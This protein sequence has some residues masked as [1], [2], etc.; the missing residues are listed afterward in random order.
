MPNKEIGS[1]KPVITVLRHEPKN[2]KTIKI[3]LVGQPNVGKSMLI[4]SISN[5]RLK[6]GNFSGVTVTKEQVFLNLISKEGLTT[7]I[8]EK[9]VHT[10]HLS[11]LLNEMQSVHRE[12]PNAIW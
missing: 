9:T 7:Q 6:V 10:A 12:H 4:N 3:A 8:L 11:I 5:A 2:N 1:V